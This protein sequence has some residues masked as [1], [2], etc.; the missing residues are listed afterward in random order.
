MFNRRPYLA[1]A[2]FLLLL[3]VLL[4]ILVQLRLSVDFDFGTITWVQDIVPRALDLPF[5]ILSLLGSA[6]ITAVF[7][8]VV[9]FLLYRP[10]DKFL[11]A[12]AFLLVTLIEAIGK[13]VIGQPGPPKELHHT[14]RFFP[15]VSTSIRTPFGFPSGHAAR[16]MLIAFILAAWLL[17][18]NL[19]ER[20][21]KVLFALLVAGEIV[22]LVSRVSLGE[23]WTTDVIAGAL[24]SAACGL[25]LFDRRRSKL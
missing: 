16:S 24:L 17:Q 14:F 9:L 7:V 21:R 20:T 15:M 1:L 25:A 4:A 12:G 11:W 19:P 8:F 10:P 5:S 18:S 13:N 2:L 22:M 23:H 6:E 3:F